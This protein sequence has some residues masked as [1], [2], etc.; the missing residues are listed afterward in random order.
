MFGHI[1]S[2]SSQRKGVLQIGM[3]VQRNNHISSSQD[4]RV[5]WPD[6]GCYL[7]VFAGHDHDA[8]LQELEVSAHNGYIV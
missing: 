2:E 6:N 5:G 8:T 3:V 7:Q 4:Q 1:K